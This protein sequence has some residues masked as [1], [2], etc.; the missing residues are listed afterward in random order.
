MLSAMASIS[1]KIPTKGISCW[2][3]DGNDAFSDEAAVASKVQF[4]DKAAYS[5]V[6]ADGTKGDAHYV[7]HVDKGTAF[8]AVEAPAV[9]DTRAMSSLAGI[10]SDLYHEVGGHQRPRLRLGGGRGREAL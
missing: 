8:S 4:P 6:N 7:A 2:H 1:E 9:E 3:V 10:R 5:D